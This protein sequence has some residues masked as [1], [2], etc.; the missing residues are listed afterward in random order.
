MIIISEVI[1]HKTRMKVLKLGY[2]V[3]FSS[4]HYHNDE[5]SHLKVPRSGCC[6]SEWEH[7]SERHGALKNAPITNDLRFLFA[8]VHLYK[9]TLVW[10][11]NF[12]FKDFAFWSDFST[13]FIWC[14]CSMKGSAM[15]VALSSNSSSGSHTHL[16]HW[17]WVNRMLSVRVLDGNHPLRL[18]FYQWLFD[19]LSVV[20]QR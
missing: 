10:S 11:N 2:F 1:F 5:L 20:F 16:S 8:V 14:P 12:L 18:Y 15:S 7:R 19:F 6:M 3:A 9:D 13:V 17:N 4:Q